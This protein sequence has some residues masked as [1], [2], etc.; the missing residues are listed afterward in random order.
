[1]DAESAIEEG[2]KEKDI[3]LSALGRELGVLPQVASSVRTPPMHAV[4]RATARRGRFTRA[5]LELG[6]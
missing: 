4:Q 5:E 6:G 2:E 1:M 3:N